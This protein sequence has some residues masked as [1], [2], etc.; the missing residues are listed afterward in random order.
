MPVERKP[1]FRAEIVAP[2]AAASSLE[3]TAPAREILRRWAD[4]LASPKATALNESELL[5]DFLPDFFVTLLGYHGPS[6]PGGRYTLLR[7]KHVK[8]DGKFADAVLG[9]FS[10]RAPRYS[11]PWRAGFRATRSTAPTRAAAC[12]AV[13][14]AY[15]YAI[16]LP[17]HYPRHQSVRPGCITRGATST[18]SNCSTSDPLP[19][20]CRP[21]TASCTSPGRAGRPRRRPC[22]LYFF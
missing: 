12:T 11:S 3:D 7:E 14:Q 15:R 2:R 17:C 10:P 16:N 4:L 1:L 9:E 18:R 19:R 13:D 22:H 20:R 5:P 21:S 6:G 8:V